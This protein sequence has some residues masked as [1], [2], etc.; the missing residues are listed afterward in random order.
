MMAGIYVHIPFCHAKCAYC[1][2]F[3]TPKMS[4]WAECVTDGIIAE[5]EARRAEISDHSIETIYFGGGTP[6]CMPTHML[7]RICEVLPMTDAAEITIE[8]N[9]E[10]VNMKSAANWR[11]L[12]FNRV[13]MGV[14]SLD[15]KEL[16]TVGRRHSAHEAIQ[17]LDFLHAAGFD[18]ISCDLI[19][20]LP[21]QTAQS[22]E[23][24]V[25]A[26]I[27]GGITHMSAYCLSFEPGTRLS[28]MLS[29]GKIKEAPDDLIEEMYA[30][31]CQAMSDAGFEHYEISNFARTGM[32]SRH[33]SSYWHSVPYLGL[34][35][36]AHSCDGMGVRRAAPADIADW[37]RHGAQIEEETDIDRINDTIITGLRTS[38]GLDLSRLPENV[39]AKIMRAAHPYIL[40]G[41]LV[42][43]ACSLV[44][45]EPYWLVSDAI[46]RDLLLD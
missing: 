26:L 24:S 41:K 37:L 13:S 16:V 21:G 9:P 3:S 46:M 14:Q 7:A 6:S 28:A 45:P 20:G 34:G 1:D 8:V 4:E 39:C 36:A 18:N 23:R 27:A 5:Y 19:Y 22:W 17:A 15:D 43:R 42:R 11:S 33:N 40:C 2:F 38:D 35:P 10:D 25:S 30:A 31:L 12:G 29:V 32:R 44:I